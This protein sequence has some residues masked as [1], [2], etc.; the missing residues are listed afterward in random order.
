MKRDARGPWAGG[1]SR[2]ILIVAA[3]VAGVVLL[4]AI[5]LSRVGLEAYKPRVQAVASAALGQDV[6][7]RG[8]MAIGVFPGVHLSLGDV[9]VL[10]R[11][12]AEFASFRRTDVWVALLPLLYG[13]VRLDKVA[14]AGA[15]LT[16]AR[17]KDGQYNVGPLERARGL[18][19]SRHLSNLSLSD[20]S[21][22]YQDAA[23]GKQFELRGCELNVKGLRLGSGNPAERLKRLSFTAQFA[24]REAGGSNV[25]LSDIKLHAVAKDGVFDVDPATL[26]VFGGSAAGTVHA[27]L[28]G[29][30]PSF[31]VR[32]SLAQ[33]RIEEF[34]ATFSP[35]KSVE[36]LMD[37]SANL[38]LHGSTDRELM[39]TAQGEVGLRGRDLTLHGND[40][41]RVLRRFESSQNFSLVDVGAYVLVG[42]FGPAVTKGINF[43]GNLQGAGG[44]TRIGLAVSEWRVADGVAQAKDVAM[45]TSTNRIAMQGGLDFVH[46]RFADV[47]LAV[48][49]A[50]G[51]AR[52]RQRVVGSFAKPVV[53]KPRVLTSLAGP[54]VELLGR[55]RR[56]LPSGPCKA[57]YAGSVPAPQRR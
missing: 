2:R 27:D 48:V 34:F 8:R 44:E 11:G 36:G 51:C 19:L 22:R 10:T 53:E 5:V 18:A 6:R 28:S 57:F 14:L 33:F 31:V 30:V 40:V 20:G 39:R 17:G 52:V 13:D 23:S 55:M 21:L 16:V 7:I 46:Q 49:D 45:A 47:T 56:V 9:H 12:G 3:C 32:G 37:F 1:T 54:V 41:D 43:A 26:R 35:R 42:P 38:A 29:P 24:C 4:A 25:T 15:S 50:N